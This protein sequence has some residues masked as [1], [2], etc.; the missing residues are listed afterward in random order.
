MKKTTNQLVLE[1]IE[2]L[3]KAN[4]KE[5]QRS[6]KEF[7][8]DK[9]PWLFLGLDIETQP[10]TYTNEG[11]KQNYEAAFKVLLDNR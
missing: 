4:F 9:Y 8:I 3:A 5:G 1:R 2:K 6:V 10:C 11:I 7:E